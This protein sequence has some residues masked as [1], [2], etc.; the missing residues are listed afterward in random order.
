MHGVHRV[1]GRQTIPE[2]PS[3]MHG[4][5]GKHTIAVAMVSATH[6][7]KPTH[8][9]DCTTALSLLFRVVDMQSLFTSSNQHAAIRA[10]GHRCDQR[11]MTEVRSDRHKVPAQGPCVQLTM[12]RNHCANVV[13][14][15][16]PAEL[17]TQKRVLNLCTK[18]VVHWQPARVH[19]QKSAQELYKGGGPLA[20]NTTAHTERLILEVAASG[21]RLFGVFCGIS[22]NAHIEREIVKVAVA[23]ERL[24]GMFLWYQQKCTH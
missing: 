16:R 22:R 10:P 11:L 18:A 13:T 9:D 17:H 24:V 15:W 6:K 7:W 4:D 14:H 2:A 12:L 5:T 8:L 21:E 3:R 23:L 1:T 20:T 19:T